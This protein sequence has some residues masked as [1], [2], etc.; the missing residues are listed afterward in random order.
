MY[1][2]GKVRR[3]DYNTIKD[4]TNNA[5]QEQTLKNIYGTTNY[6]PN[7]TGLS[8]FDGKITI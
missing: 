4:D 1:P 2:K 6:G 7:A 8:T 3:M 5:V